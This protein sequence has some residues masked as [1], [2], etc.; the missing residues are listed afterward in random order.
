MNPDAIA[1]GTSVLID[2]NIL[3]YAVRQ[4]SNQSLALLER[5]AAG[6]L[7]GVVTS[8]VIAEFCHRRMMLEAA[9]AGLVGSNPARALAQKPRIVR[10]LSAY[11]DDVR[12][13]LDGGLSFEPVQREDFLLALEL[14][15]KHALLTNDSLNLAVARRL[16][17]TEVATADANFDRI[18]GIRAHK[19]ADLRA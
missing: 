4:A 6:E 9:G 3:L 16:S 18:P 17:I 5:C 15:S 13:L 1:A 7:N 12:D 11:A 19:P 14:Q 2:A 8:I 10:S